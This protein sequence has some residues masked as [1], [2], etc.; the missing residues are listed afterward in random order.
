MLD[1]TVLITGSTAGIG[2]AS[3]RSLA[4]AGARV[5][6]VGRN[7]DRAHQAAQQLRADTGNPSIEA[8]RADVSS[9]ADL[10]R[11][12]DTIS[13]THDRLDVLINNAGVNMATRV[14]N[15]DGV[16]LDFA[17]NVLAPFT[18]SHALLPLLRRS[19]DGRIVNLT[20]GIPRGPIDP[21][22]LQGEKTYIGFT[23]SQYNHSKLALMAVSRILA[24]RFSADGVSVNVAY[25][26][27]AFTP[28]NQAMPAAALPVL[29]RP[30]A[31]LLRLAG[32][33]LMGD[34][35][36][37]R[38]SRSSVYLATSAEVTGVSG[39]YFDKN[40]RRADWPASVT[41][42]SSQEA[43]W[44]LCKRLSADA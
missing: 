24:E 5:L 40:C 25:P 18:L 2:L 16:E 9:S 30:M 41:D 6:L 37:D 12:A 15:P 11:L 8:Y 23:F 43:V 4:R 38:A 33:L 1:R 44:R 10:A 29:Y 21:D 35:A 14:L 32:P 7:A 42:P 13:R 39:A 26:G 34:K 28:G 17:T 36:I 22:N 19:V 31:P 27:H 3:A 20:G